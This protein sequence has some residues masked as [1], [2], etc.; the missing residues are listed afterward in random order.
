MTD[1]NHIRQDDRR[2]R[3]CRVVIAAGPYRFAARSLPAGSGTVQTPPA[4]GIA[5]GSG[6]GRRERDRIASPPRGTR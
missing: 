6:Q 5:F 3:P 4:R 1:G 2:G